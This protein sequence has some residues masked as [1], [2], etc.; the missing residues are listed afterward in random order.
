MKGFVAIQRSIM[1]SPIYKDSDAVH[2]W[3]H[4]T[5]KANHKDNEFMM[6]GVMVKVNRGQLITGRSS[7]AEATGIHNSKI[8]R[9]LKTFEKIGLIEQ[10]TN[11]RNR[12]ITLLSYD[13][14]NESEQQVNNTRTTDEHLVNTNNNVNNENNVN[15]SSS[16]KNK[17]SDEDM[18]A[19]S[20]IFSKIKSMDDSIKDPNMESW[21]N[22]V[23]LMRER[24]KLS[25]RDIC[26]VFDWAN[27]DSFW[28]VNILSPSK[29]RDKYSDLKIKMENAPAP[30]PERK[31][32]AQLARGEYEVSGEKS[33]VAIAADKFDQLRKDTKLLESTN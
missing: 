33:H 4:L 12:R 9:L 15:K 28:R 5:L 7:L 18:K 22:T 2:L 23:R 32:F 16:Q 10:H 14:E 21:A 20:W 6:N 24:D 17:F 27:K 31:S 11:N 8:Q 1:E 13:E 29:L 3:L 30:K 26:R 19:A 25:H